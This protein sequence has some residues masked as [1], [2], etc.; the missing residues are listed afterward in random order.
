[1]KN[2]KKVTAI[3]TAVVLATISI[4]SIVSADYWPKGRSSAKFNAYYDSSVSSYGYTSAFDAGREGWN[5]ISSNVAIGKTSSTSGLNDKYYVGTTTN[6]RLVGQASYYS[7]SGTPVD[8][9]ALRAYST[10]AL[11]HNTLDDKFPGVEYRT[12]AATHEIGHTLS[13]GETTPN[14]NSVMQPLLQK[15]GV[16]TYDKNELKAKWGN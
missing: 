2:V 1:M 11:Y 7:P 15:I 8:R 4:S 9:E 5:G 3:A 13:L 12:S 6:S 16:Q 10:V 14:V